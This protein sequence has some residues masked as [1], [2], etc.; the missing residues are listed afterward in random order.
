MKK[1]KVTVS[2]ISPLLQAR[3]P[4]PN[5]L[6]KMVLRMKKN[7][8]VGKKMTN[9]DADEQ[10]KIHSYKTKSNKFFQPSEMIE[11]AMVKAATSFRMEGK[12]TYKDAFKAG[13]FV[14]PAQIVHKYQKFTKDERWAK[15][16]STRGA[17]WVV[18]PCI[19]KWELSFFINLLLDERIPEE[20]IREVLSYAGSFVGIGAWRPKHG[21]FEIK[22]FEEV[23][24]TKKKKVVKKNK[25]N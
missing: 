11:A 18:R 21:R 1:F 19:D 10:F 23:S 16:P 6:A 3:H 24:Q 5:E 12:K 2:G 4:S 8:T 14:D 13:L 22:S 17:I 7:G 25:K 20:V 9:L 15:N